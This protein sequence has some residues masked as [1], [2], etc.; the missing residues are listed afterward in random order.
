MHMGG[1]GHGGSMFINVL[2]ITCCFILTL[3]GG[4]GGGVELARAVDSGM[5]WHTLR[6]CTVLYCTV[7]L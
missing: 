3:T 5:V 4:G 6:Y 1:S 2:I 7:L